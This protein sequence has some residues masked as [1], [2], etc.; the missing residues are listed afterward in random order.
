MTD[1]NTNITKIAELRQWADTHEPLETYLWIFYVMGIV[2]ILVVLAFFVLSLGAPKNNDDD[3]D[4]DSDSDSD[5]SDNDHLK[6][7]KNLPK[8][9]TDPRG[10]KND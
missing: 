1:I 4:S 3:S 9:L 7:N 5:D 6:I 8:S 10:K 2:F